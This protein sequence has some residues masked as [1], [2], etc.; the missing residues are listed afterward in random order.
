M[1]RRSNAPPGLW[2]D[3]ALA[4]FL[5]F[6]GLMVIFENGHV[7]PPEIL[8]QKTAFW[9]HWGF[10]PWRFGRLAGVARRQHFV[11]DGFLGRIAE[12]G[13]WD[14]IIWE[15]GSVEDRE[16]LWHSLVPRPEVMTQRFLFLLPEPKPGRRIKSFWLGFRGYAEFYEYRPGAGP[17]VGKGEIPADLS[18]LVDLALKDDDNAIQPN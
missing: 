4:A 9:E 12:Y 14:H 3:A 18:G 17:A 13:A 5:D 2:P 15:T 8:S 10:E 6:G 1:P 11:K 16:Q 7:Q